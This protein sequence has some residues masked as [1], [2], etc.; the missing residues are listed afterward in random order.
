MSDFR[1]IPFELFFHEIVIDWLFF[2]DLLMFLLFHNNSNVLYAHFST[3]VHELWITNYISS[4]EVYS[5]DGR[6]M[7]IYVKM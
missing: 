6:D 5:Y 3:S 2:N 1:F 4:W 7:M